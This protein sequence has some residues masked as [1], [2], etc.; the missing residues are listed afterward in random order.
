S[1]TRSGVLAGGRALQ[2][3][4]LQATLDGLS[5]QPYAAAGVLSLGFAP[6]EPAFQPTL[7]ALASAL[8]D[9]CGPGHGLVFLRL[10]RARSAPRQCSGRRALASFGAS[11]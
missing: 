5:V 8:G 1:T 7:S 10:G 11:P 3:V 9:L 2:R 6:V 4:L